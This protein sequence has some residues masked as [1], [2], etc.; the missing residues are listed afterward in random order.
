MFT[1]TRRS[2]RVGRC[3]ICGEPIT[4]TQVLIEYETA[5]GIRVYAECRNCSDVVHPE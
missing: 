2:G 1:N 3:P 5:T 4:S